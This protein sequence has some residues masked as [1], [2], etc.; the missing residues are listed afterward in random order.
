MKAVIYSPSL[1][2]PTPCGA[3]PHHTDWYIGN[4]MWN[5]ILFASHSLGRSAVC[6]FSRWWRWKWSRYLPSA[7]YDNKELIDDEASRDYDCL[8]IDST[9]FVISSTTS[10]CMHF[11]VV[12]LLVLVSSPLFHAIKEAI[13]NAR[14]PKGGENVKKGKLKSFWEAFPSIYGDKNW[15]QSRSGSFFP[16][17]PLEKGISNWKAGGKFP[18]TAA[19]WGTCR[20]IL[21]IERSSTFW[22]P[23]R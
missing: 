22:T 8:N 1:P 7:E 12:P 3:S 19:T 2:L 18:S 5:W 20:N 13:N 21:Q 6:A 11:I 10:L 16:S 23:H 9:G 15:Q 17:V 14:E 4:F